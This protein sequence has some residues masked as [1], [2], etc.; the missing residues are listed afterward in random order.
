MKR[1]TWLLFIVVLVMFSS[2]VYAED[3][4]N[5]KEVKSGQWLEDCDIDDADIDLSLIHI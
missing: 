5:G 4:K 3:T 1:L 2:P